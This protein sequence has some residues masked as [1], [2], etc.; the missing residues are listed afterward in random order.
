MMRARN[1]HYFAP[2]IAYVVW[3]PLRHNISLMALHP[4]PPRSVSP[5]HLLELFVIQSLEEDTPLH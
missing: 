4:L 3:V 5:E 2:M 1:T